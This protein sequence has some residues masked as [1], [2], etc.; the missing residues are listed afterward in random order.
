MTQQLQINPEHDPEALGQV[1][2]KEGRLQVA[3][4]FS[5]DT[6]DYLHKIHMENQDWYLAY[7]EG[8]S[9]FERSLEQLQALNPQQRQQF[10]NSIN[11]RARTQF[12]Y[13]F[14]Q[15][16]ISQA[17]ELEE[18]PGHPMHQIHEFLNSEEVLNLMRALTGEDAVRKAD[19]YASNYAPGHFLTAHDDRH[20]SHDRVAAFVFSMTKVW[21]KNWGGHL[22]FFDDAGN[23]TDALIPSFNT[24]NIFLV[25]QMHSV[26]LVSPFAGANRS[27]Y[28]GWLHR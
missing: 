19:C 3:D 15:Y 27:S 16:Y 26:Q 2:Q 25:P 7:N 5:P 12:Q 10:M 17:I 1:L 8:S 18:Q 13:V 11:A 22:A 28:L 20:D 4:F 9:F 6:A 24:L 21:D 23:I 14:F